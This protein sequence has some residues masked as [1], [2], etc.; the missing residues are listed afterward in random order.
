M[1]IFLTTHYLDEADELADHLAIMDHGEIVTEG[2]PLEL[3]SQI[4]ETEVA[5]RIK[6]EVQ[7]NVTLDDVFL[8]V[9]GRSLRDTGKEEE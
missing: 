6:R 1:T 7:T 2:T 5:E 8:K 9:T 4:S 3:K